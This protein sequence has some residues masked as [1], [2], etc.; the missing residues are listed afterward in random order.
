[1]HVTMYDIVVALIHAK[2]RQYR[3]HTSNEAKPYEPKRRGWQ[4]VRASTQR[5][6]ILPISISLSRWDCS[7]GWWVTALSFNGSQRSLGRCVVGQSPNL[8]IRV[9][10]DASL[11]VTKVLFHQTFGTTQM[12]LLLDKTAV[13]HD[14]ATWVASA[15]SVNNRRGLNNMHNEDNGITRVSML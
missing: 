1:M 4:F 15:G 8:P 14:V 7:E 13:N 3:H 9:I 11:A 10:W 6:L 2:Q 5:Q 12:P